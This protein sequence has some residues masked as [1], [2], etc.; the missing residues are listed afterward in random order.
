MTLLTRDFATKLMLYLFITHRFIQG[1]SRC[2]LINFDPPFVQSGSEGLGKYQDD[3]P[4]D[5]WETQQQ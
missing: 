2:S 3:S 4:R 5:N 1:A